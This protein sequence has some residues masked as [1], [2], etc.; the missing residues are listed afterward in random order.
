MPGVGKQGSSVIIFSIIITIFYIDAHAEIQQSNLSTSTWPQSP[1]Y[2]TIP[3][4]FGLDL[5]YKIH[6][7]NI[8]Q[9]YFL[10][11]ELCWVLWK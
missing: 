5:K 2:T 11:Q 1:F 10:C 4:A 8:Y 6:S 3:S 9:A 7:T